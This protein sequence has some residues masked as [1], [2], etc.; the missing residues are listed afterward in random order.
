MNTFQRADRLV[1][2]GL[3]GVVVG[4]TLV[5]AWPRPTAIYAVYPGR[6]VTEVDQ[7]TGRE[8]MVKGFFVPGSVRRRIG[9]CGLDFE[10][11]SSDVPG[12]R[13]L[14]VDFD[15]C[16]YPEALCDLPDGGPL[17]VYA[18]CSVWATGRLERRGG[19]VHFRT[20]QLS[21]PSGDAYEMGVDGRALFARPNRCGQWR[22]GYV[23]PIC[24]HAVGQA[25]AGRSL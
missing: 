2:L 13:D 19:R 14:V 1:W 7:W 12:T 21:A 17:G 20:T 6:A 24:E 23:C 11:R 8:V 5:V 16:G 15:S 22:A 18:S 4:V 9:R 25:S 10:L 3:L